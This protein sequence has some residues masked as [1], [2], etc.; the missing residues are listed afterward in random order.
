[1]LLKIGNVSID[2]HSSVFKLMH[3]QNEIQI[4]LYHTD[5]VGHYQM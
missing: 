4:Q 3:F 2:C 5:A 1:M